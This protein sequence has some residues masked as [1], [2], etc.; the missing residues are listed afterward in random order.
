MIDVEYGT[1]AIGFTRRAIPR[2]AILEPSKTYQINV[3]VEGIT[4]LEA[5]ADYLLC[6]LNK[7]YPQV[8]VTWINV[9]EKT[10]N[11]QFRLASPETL[12]YKPTLAVASI[13][14][15]LP[16]ILA[17]IGVIVTLISVVEL[18]RAVPW[19]VW[20][21]LPLGVV[22]ILWGPAIAKALVAGVPAKYR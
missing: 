14:V 6:E 4:D 21:G 5:V 10:I 9:G 1:R 13:I 18:Y 7:Q 17:L 20:L 3:D 19:Y 15:W 2:E 8:Q 22:L 16:T 11:F 12:G